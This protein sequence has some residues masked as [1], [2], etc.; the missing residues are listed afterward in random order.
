MFRL[1]RQDYISCWWNCSGSGSK[2]ARVFSDISDW[3]VSG[4]WRRARVYY[5]SLDCWERGG[6]DTYLF[7][8][9]LST[10]ALSS[11]NVFM[12][13]VNAREKKDLTSVLCFQL[14]VGVLSSN[15]WHGYSVIIWS[16]EN[17]TNVKWKPLLFQHCHIPVPGSWHRGSEQASLCVNVFLFSAKPTFCIWKQVF[18]L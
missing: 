3:T 2:V 10:S 1:C 18:W 13:N 14:K 4:E 9:L 6:V 16:E 8:F 7:I 12:P 17:A 11:A 15:K 5:K